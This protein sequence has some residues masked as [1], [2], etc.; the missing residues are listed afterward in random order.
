MRLLGAA[1]KISIRPF[2]LDRV[3][4]FTPHGVW[5]Q[6]RSAILASSVPKRTM[7]S[8]TSWLGGARPLAGNLVEETP[9]H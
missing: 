1:G 9:P 3:N 2:G 8:A 5:Y 4:K 6:A 7:E